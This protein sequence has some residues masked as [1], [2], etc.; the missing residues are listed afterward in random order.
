LLREVRKTYL[1]VLIMVKLVEQPPEF[2]IVQEK[3]VIV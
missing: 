2:F 1:A 3:V